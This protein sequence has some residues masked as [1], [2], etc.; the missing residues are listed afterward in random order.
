MGTAPRNLSSISRAILS[1][2]PAPK[3]LILSPQWGQISPDMF[4]T[5]P[6]TGIF[7]ARTMF[8]ALRL[9]SNATSWGVVTIIAPASSGM[10]WT[11]ERGS[12]LVPGGRS[13]SKKSRSPQSTSWMNCLMAA[14]FMGPRQTT[15]ESRLERRKAM[16]AA[17]I[18]SASAGSIPSGPCISRA[19]SIPNS[20]AMSGPVIS[21][22]RMPTL[23]PFICRARARLTVTVLFPTPPLPL[24]M[25]ILCLTLAMRSTL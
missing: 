4:S 5:I 25:M 22:S 8:T 3:M 16:E 12:S 18:P 10:S 6:R 24:A 7:I 20:F 17:L 19:S 15:G 14:I 21:A 11:T 9:S 1:P 2:P 23:K 13:M